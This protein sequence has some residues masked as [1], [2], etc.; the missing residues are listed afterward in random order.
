MIFLAQSVDGTAFLHLECVASPS[1]E[2]TETN[3]YIS[4]SKF[5]DPEATAILT[6]NALK[7]HS[8]QTNAVCDD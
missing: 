8:G 3:F 4:T 5:L 7:N 2:V 6:H 1:K